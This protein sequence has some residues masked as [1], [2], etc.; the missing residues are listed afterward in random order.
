MKYRGV[1]FGFGSVR[2]RFQLLTVL[3]GVH[4][5]HRPTKL[6]YRIPKELDLSPVVG[7]FTT[8]IRVGQFDIQFTFGVVDF[9][10]ISPVDLFRGNQVIGHWEEGKWPEA[11]FYDIMNT[12]VTYWEVKTERLIIM[13][14]ANG[15]E[16]HLVDDSDQYECMKICFEG[17]PNLYII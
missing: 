13:R 12:E 9:V 1:A 8:Q 17:N 5:E 10:I 6:M 2:R 7:Q 15:I 11:A 3:A 14:F 16:M 4:D